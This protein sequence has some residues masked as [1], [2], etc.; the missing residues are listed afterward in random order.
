LQ[1]RAE[2]PAGLVG[3]AAGDQGPHDADPQPEEP[4]RPHG[5]THHQRDDTDDGDSDDDDVQRKWYL[6]GHGLGFS[7]DGEDT[8]AGVAATRSPATGGGGWPASR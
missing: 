5:E 7:V 2:E 4:P 3:D 6:G 1:G 8:A